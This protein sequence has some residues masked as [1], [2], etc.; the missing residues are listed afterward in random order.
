MPPLAW[1]RGRSGATFRAIE[2]APMILATRC[3]IALLIGG[4]AIEWR[5]SPRQHAKQPLLRRCG[6]AALLTA[7]LHPRRPPVTS[8][9]NGTS[10]PN[11]VGSASA[12]GDLRAAAAAAGTARTD[13]SGSHTASP[14]GSAECGANA[15]ER[16]RQD[17]Q[18]VLR[19]RAARRRLEHLPLAKSGRGRT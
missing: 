6:A 2:G 9:M 19:A 13:L 14:R 4:S 5:P 18:R 17:R 15:P 11:G 12:C 16:D 7:A 3:P 10:K 1:A 8:V